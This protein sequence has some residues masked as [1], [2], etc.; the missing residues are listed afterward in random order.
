[1]AGGEGGDVDCSI[2]VHA[3]L[4]THVSWY[5]VS[6]ARIRPTTTLRKPLTDAGQSSLLESVIINTFLYF[7][8]NGVAT[9]RQVQE[10]KTSRRHVGRS[11]WRV[12]IR[13]G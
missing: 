8:K 9:S 12:C 7:F 4:R 11:C 3:Y 6:D 13:G 5:I 10:M 2:C 1:M